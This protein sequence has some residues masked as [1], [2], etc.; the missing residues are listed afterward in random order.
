MNEH[1]R[2]WLRKHG[3]TEIAVK[4]IDIHQKILLGKVK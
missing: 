1:Q 2:K 3:Y 4:E